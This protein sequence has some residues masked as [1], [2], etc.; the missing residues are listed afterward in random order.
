VVLAHCTIAP[1]LVED[2]HLHTHFESGIGVGISGTIPAGPVTLVRL[3]GVGLERRW[4]ADAEV[5]GT[6][7][8][9]DLCRTQATVRLDPAQVAELL[10]APLGN[11]VVLVPGHHAARLDRWWRLVVA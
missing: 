3:G 4:L 5:V 2:L 6:G 8:D 9:P 7:E 10:E 11:H 1:S